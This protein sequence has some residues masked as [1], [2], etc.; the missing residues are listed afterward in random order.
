MRSMFLI[1]RFVTFS[2]FSFLCTAAL[3]QT[4]APDKACKPP[5]NRQLFHDYVDREQKAILRLDGKPDNLLYA[6]DNEDVNYMVSMALSQKINNLQCKIETDSLIQDRVKV[7]YLRGL[8]KV[9]KNFK[10]QYRTP[11]FHVSNFPDVVDTYEAAMELD[12]RGESIEPVIR[13]KGYEVANMVV[14]SGAFDGNRWI[15]AARHTLLR[16]YSYVY[17]DRILSA[18]AKTENSQVPFRD[19]LIEVAAYKHPGQLYNYASANNRLGSAIRNHK[20]SLVRTIAK[21]ATSGGSGQMYF[22]FLD[23]ILKGSITLE[24]IDAIKNDDVKYYK[25]LVKTRMDYMNRVRNKETVRG[26]DDLTS[27]LE[28]KAKD[29]FVKQ[30]NALHNE[31]DA[32]RFRILNQLSPQ[33]LYYVAVSSESEIYTSSYTRGVYPM[34]M[35]RMGNRGDSLL[36]SVGF[37]RFKKWIKLAA[38]FNTLNDFLKSFPNQED[39]RSLMRAFVNNLEKSGGLEDGVDVADSYV[40]ISEGNKELADFV[41]DLTKQNYEKSLAQNNHRGKVIYNLLYKLFL[42]ADTSSNINLSKEFGIPPVYNVSYDALASDS[43]QR[44]VMQMFFY[45]DRDGQNDFR[46]Y[47]GQFNSSNWKI[48]NEKQWVTISSTKGKPVVIFANRPLPEETGQDEEAQDAMIAYM[49]SKGYVPTIVIHRG[50]SYYAPYTIENV[51]PSAKIVFLGS[52]G[53]YHL[54]HDVLQRSPDAHIIASKQIGKTVINQPF[55]NLMNEKLRNGNGI[56]WIPFWKEFGQVVTDKEGFQD[57]IPPHKNLGAIFIK[58]YKTQMGET[59]T[60]EGIM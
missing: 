9:L 34:I 28:K 44:V 7:L 11:Q 60:E 43:S 15:T 10:A 54:I 2:I 23:A 51:R 36:V 16:K 45:G 26:L 25:L 13:K 8:E 48:S 4:G 49:D 31:P 58:A 57:Y 1:V 38:G 33:E 3:A 29:V 37:D 47:L 14:T 24:Q 19:S 32:V 55:F 21:M 12:K 42:S 41:L 59:D 35:Q 39:T 27:R 20:D 50:H 52:C 53:G 6:S 46:S 22:P 18:L 56:D 5:I 30:I 40:S 17:P